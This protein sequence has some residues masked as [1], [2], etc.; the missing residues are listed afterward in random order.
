MKHLR[1]QVVGE[2]LHGKLVNPFLSSLRN[3]QGRNPAI[4]EHERTEQ[5]VN[6]GGNAVDIPPSLIFVISGRGF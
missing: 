4:K 2:N 5:S 6:L 1:E 3:E